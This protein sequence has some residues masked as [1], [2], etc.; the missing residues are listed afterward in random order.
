MRNRISTLLGVCIRLRIIWNLQCS[1][2]S[3]TEHEC[4][5]QHPVIH[6]AICGRGFWFQLQTYIKPLQSTS[7]IKVYT[8]K[9]PYSMF[10]HTHSKGVKMSLLCNCECNLSQI[11]EIKISCTS[12]NMFSS[13]CPAGSCVLLGVHIV[14][15]TDTAW[16][17]AFHR[18]IGLLCLI[19][20][21]LYRRSY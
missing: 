20:P 4:C 7:G 3:K 5:T 1:F 6:T 12:S 10:L 2:G 21:T 13:S 11:H 17:S 15:V 14:G 8:L 19:W 9:K 18:L 16:S